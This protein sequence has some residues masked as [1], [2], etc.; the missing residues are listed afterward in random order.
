MLSHAQR[1]SE[2]RVSR[3]ASFALGVQMVGAVLTAILTIYLGRALSPDQYGDLTFALSVLVIASLFADIGITSSTGRFLRRAPRRPDRCGQRVCHR[4]AAEAARSAWSPRSR[5]SRSQVRSA[6]CSAARARP[7]RFAPWR[8][9]C[10]PRGCSC[11]SW[12]RSTRSAGSGTTSSS[13]GRERRGSALEH[14][15]VLLG[16]RCDWC[17]AWQ[18]A[19][20]HR[21]RAGRPG[22]CQTGGRRSAGLRA[23]SRRRC[24]AARS[25]ATPGRCC[26]STRRFG[27]SRASTC[28]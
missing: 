25:S 22:G 17:G 16:A 15:L 11:C 20:L 3:S 28:C 4:R 19:G 21:R 2:E 9:R 23:A 27:C 1:M 7:G 13:R 8:S 18:R 5:C 24:R 14:R 26:S 10:W 6:I 12:A